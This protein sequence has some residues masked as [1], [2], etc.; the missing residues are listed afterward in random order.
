MDETK[1]EPTGEHR[2]ID[3]SRLIHLITDVVTE[4]RLGENEGLTDTPRR[5]A[6]MYLELFSGVDQDPE[7]LL[8]TYGG[9]SLRAYLINSPVVRGEPLKFSEEGVKLVTAGQ[10]ILSNPETPPYP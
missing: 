1:I 2:T 5:I 7:E 9:D 4:L 3:R 6:D 8:N 10:H